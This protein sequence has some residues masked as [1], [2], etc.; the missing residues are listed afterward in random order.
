MSLKRCITTAMCAFLLAVI[1]LAARCL[2]VQAAPPA[3]TGIPLTQP[4]GTTITARQWGDEWQHGLETLDG[5][6]IIPDANGTWVY[7]LVDAGGDLAPLK[8]GGKMLV[9]GRDAP[10]NLARHARPA[11]ANR[12]LRESAAVGP[13]KFSPNTG[14][15]PLLVV[16]VEFMNIRHT[17]PATTF[18]TSVFGA[19]NSVVDFYK[20]ASFNQ[21]TIIPPVET[22][23][24]AND[25]VV[26]WLHL[27]GNYSNNLSWTEIA[28][29]AL[30]AA[31]L[32]V[33]YAMYDQDGDGSVTSAE[34]H[35][36]IVV[37]GYEQSYCGPGCNGVWAHQ[38]TVEDLALDGVTLAAS[39]PD[40]D[41]GGYTMFGEIHGF[42]DNDS[43][44]PD[45][46]ATI[47][48][49]AHELG[50]D[51]SW[52]DL[53]DTN[54]LVNGS[55]S[56]AGEWSIMGS[57]SWNYVYGVTQ[58]GGTPALPDAWLKAYQGWVSPTLAASGDTY[59]LAAAGSSATALQLGSNPGGIDWDF[60]RHSG[61]GEYWLVENRQLS[62]YDAGLPGCGILIWHVDEAVTPYNTANGN[63]ARPLLA[64]EE[65]D[66]RADLYNDVGRG[67]AGDAYPGAANNRLFGQT[68]SPNSRYHS[69]DFSD[70]TL[71]IDSASCGSTMQVQYNAVHIDQSQQVFLPFVTGRIPAKPPAPFT[72]K[73]TFQGVPWAGIPL[74]MAYSTDYGSSWELYYASTTTNSRGDF[75]FANPPAVGGSRRFVVFF[76]NPMNI[77]AYLWY[78]ECNAVEDVDDSYTCDIDLQDIV[79]VSP[80]DGAYTSSWVNFS[81]QKRA[82]PTDDYY[83]RFFDSYTTKTYF[84]EMGYVDSQSINFCNFS[85]GYWHTWWMDVGTPSGYGFGYH[86]NDLQFTSVP[87]CSPGYA[88]QQETLKPDAGDALARTPLLNWMLDE[89]KM[90]LPARSKAPQEK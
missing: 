17:Y 70:Q 86:T 7:A 52:P 14:A 81:W 54:D 57:G 41:L 26:G 38:S 24:T 90:T 25:G 59:T 46:P 64:L 65:A 67:D 15:Q 85:A 4:D 50:H 35:T 68:S 20:T 40:G 18:R 23:G 87:F 72:G 37:A 11:A 77:P 82:F 19:S 36:M 32:Y 75:A 73:V 60:T 51:L 66:G 58:D 71:N 79:P 10:V 80:A 34:L 48:V 63:P 3:P 76:D 55:W 39:S 29:E 69:G 44:Y 88:A 16:L 33:D 42:G 56:G 12:P 2:S 13:A 83:F 1:L 84:M 28:R 53:Y 45:H 78:F 47:G 49:M 22:Y 5:Y 30:R 61:T 6:T 43:Y 27:A 21:L 9:A 62:G 8:E 31:D 89:G 74:N